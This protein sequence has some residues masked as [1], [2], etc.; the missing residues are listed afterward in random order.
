M[1]VNEKMLRNWGVE[2]PAV[3][4]N[5]MKGLNGEES[6][7][8]E[9]EKKVSDLEEALGNE[10]KQAAVEKAILEAGGKHVKAILGLI[11]MEDVTYDE[12]KGL[13]GLDMDEI[14]EEAPYLFY[15]KEEKKKGT[16]ITKSSQKKREDDIRAAFWGLK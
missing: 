6:Y 9:L 4:K 13:K 12:K 14:K 10:K 1:K 8:A 5:I 2:D 3:Q 16:G 11:D 7:V 15:E